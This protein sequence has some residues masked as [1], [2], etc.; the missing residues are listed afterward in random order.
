M[1][2]LITTYV[3]AKSI[4]SFRECVVIMGA[5]LGGTNII[6]IFKSL[7]QGTYW[8]STIITLKLGCRICRY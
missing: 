5:G 7:R 6:D 3:N 8:V 2:F 4:N 1:I